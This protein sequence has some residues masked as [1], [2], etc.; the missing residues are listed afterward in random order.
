M[1]GD[2]E[3]DDEKDYLAFKEKNDQYAMSALM[4]RKS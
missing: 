2:H 3:V 1:K 4:E